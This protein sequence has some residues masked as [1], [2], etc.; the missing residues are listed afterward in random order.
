MGM[1]TVSTFQDCGL[2]WGYSGLKCLEK[3]VDCSKHFVN[4]CSYYNLWWFLNHSGFCAFLLLDPLLQAWDNGGVLDIF[5]SFVPWSV[6][7][8]WPWPLHLERIEDRAVVM[9]LALVE[10]CGTV[11]VNSLGGHVFTRRGEGEGMW[12]LNAGIPYQNSAKMCVRS[13]VRC[14]CDLV[15]IWA[16]QA[17]PLV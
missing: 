16:L 6:W 15:C 8:A 5:V 7:Q 3:C 4:V 11:A 13:E 12:G 2:S 17:Q 9:G 14:P 1:L 10:C